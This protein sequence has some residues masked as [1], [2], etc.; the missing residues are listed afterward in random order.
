MRLRDRSIDVIKGLA[1]ILVVCGHIIQRNSVLISD[2]FFLNPVFKWIY[3]FHMPLFVFLGGYL[4]ADSLERKSGK[5]VFYSRLNSLLVPFFVWSVLGIIT[6]YALD[7]VDGKKTVGC[8]LWSAVDQLALNPA[9]W[10]LSTLFLSSVLLLFSVQLQK[11]F[12]MTVPLIVVVLLWLV[13]WNQYAGIY[14]VQWFY[15]FYLAGYFVR[16]SRIKI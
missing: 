12:G 6:N 7:L 16:N 4:M 3:S 9:V 15:P 13:P 1:I 5:E 2:D 11:R 14:Y 10:F 8:F